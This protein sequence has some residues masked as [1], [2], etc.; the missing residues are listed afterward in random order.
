MPP[1]LSAETLQEAAN[2]PVETMQMK[3][4]C[5]ICRVLPW[6][7]VRER[8]D[9]GMRPLAVGRSAGTGGR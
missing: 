1:Y 7:I 9:V 3:Y 4:Q 2:L 5:A 6:E 8:G